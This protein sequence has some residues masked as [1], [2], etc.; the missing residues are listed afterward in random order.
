MTQSGQ[1]WRATPRRQVEQRGNY[2]GGWV[3][4][5]LLR[6]KGVPSRAK[7]RLV[8]RGGYDQGSSIFI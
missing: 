3:P 2:S 8:G 4:L 6:R 5:R 7:Q 1:K